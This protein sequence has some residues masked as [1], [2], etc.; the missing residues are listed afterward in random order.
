MFQHGP[1]N[2][3]P[4]GKQYSTVGYGLFEPF[5]LKLLSGKS[6]TRTRTDGLK[7]RLPRE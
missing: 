1:K 3:P 7:A 2:G 6:E 5:A 4:P